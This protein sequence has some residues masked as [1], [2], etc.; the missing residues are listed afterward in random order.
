MT[1]RGLDRRDGR[2]HKRDE[3]ESPKAR[4]QPFCQK[5]LESKV[6]QIENAAEFERAPTGFER[7]RD[8]TSSLFTT[9]IAYKSIYNLTSS[10]SDSQNSG[11]ASAP[12]QASSTGQQGYTTTSSGNNSQVCSISL[13]KSFGGGIVI[14]GGSV[15]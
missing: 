10:M 14:L 2:V 8:S 6:K 1:Y 4:L 5:G 11:S 12:S 7:G 9:T 15:G 3:R 13:L